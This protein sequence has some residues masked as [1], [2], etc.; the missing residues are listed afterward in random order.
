MLL[1]IFSIKHYHPPRMSIYR[2]NIM[3]V[4]SPTQFI[5]FFM[6]IYFCI[7][8]SVLFL[9]IKY[10]LKIIISIIKINILF[11]FTQSQYL[12]ITCE[13]KTS[14]IHKSHTIKLVSNIQDLFFP[15]F[16]L[17]YNHHDCT[18][19]I[20]EELRRKKKTTLT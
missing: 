15:F 5:F 16:S 10:S 13:Y 7:K 3:N 6:R 9:S 17:F 8:P 11:S 19:I 12:V 14:H 2:L 4:Y 1:S 18:N 20:V